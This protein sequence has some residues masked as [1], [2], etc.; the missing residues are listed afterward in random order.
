MK[1]VCAFQVHTPFL[2]LFSFLESCLSFLKIEMLRES[3]S[4]GYHSE[5]SL[6][7]KDGIVIFIS[8]TIAFF[9]FFFK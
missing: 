3:S 7:E 1:V 5:G 2:A 6:R 8:G 4:H 9:F